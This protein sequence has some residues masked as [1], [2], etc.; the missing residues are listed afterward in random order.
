MSIIDTKSLKETTE[1]ASKHTF[2]E[3]IKNLSKEKIESSK[4]LVDLK[5][6]TEIL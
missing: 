1:K 4:F 6:K 3:W 2:C 5:D